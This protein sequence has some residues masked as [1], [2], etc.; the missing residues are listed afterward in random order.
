MQLPKSNATEKKPLADLRDV[1][2]K[3]R[4]RCGIPGMSVAVLYKGE[5]IFA[6]GFG[7]RNEQESFTAETLSLIGSVSKA[8]TATSIGEL[9][10]E[11][12]VDWDKTP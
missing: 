2:E 4:V 8:F 3:A 11:G 9:V 6:E 10:T 7:K 1:I 5:L 12:K